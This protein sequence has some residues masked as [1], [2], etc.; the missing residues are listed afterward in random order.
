VSAVLALFLSCLASGAAGAAGGA[1]ARLRAEPAR[2]DVGQP[3]R[4]ILVVQHPAGAAVRLPEAYPIPVDSWVLLEP[5]RDVRVPG[6][7]SFAGTETTRATWSVFSLEPGDRALPTI[8]VQVEADG[9]VRSIEADPG[10]LAVRSA[11]QAG[12]DA[13]RPL[14]GFHAAPERPGSRGLGF[15]LLALALLL[16][17]AGLWLWRRRKRAPSVV[18]A[19]T[20]LDRLAAIEGEVGEEPGAGQRTTYALTHLLR[21]SVDAFL[22]EDRAAL[23]DAEWSALRERDERVPLGVR[24][25]LARI[26]RD[27][28]RVKYA[29]HAPTRFAIQEMLTDARRALEALAQAT[30]PAPLTPLEEAA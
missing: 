30:P 29:R 26:L 1:S 15:G 17:M 16:G 6:T 7:G 3:V 9:A 20:P 24:T 12:E 25:T 11:L 4:W 5:R 22:R 14:R 27:A 2:A 28:E 21:A 18:L 23:V 8:V 13:P 10:S 19:A